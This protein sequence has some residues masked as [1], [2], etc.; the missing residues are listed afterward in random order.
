MFEIACNFIKKWEGFE[1]SPYLCPA[2]KLTIGY[3]TII[4]P[5]VKYNNVLG[6]ILL[7][8]SL[9]LQKQLRIVSKVNLSLKNKYPNLVSEI[10]A[11]ELMIIDLKK[12]WKFIAEYLPKG[13]TDNQCASILSLVYNIGVYAF[14]KST[15]L[16]LLQSNNFL[17]ASN[18][19]IKWNKASINGKKVE[20]KGLTN[21]RL[22]EKDLF[23][24]V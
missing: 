1:S 4:E 20:V 8:D 13:L 18:E 7:E 21:R 12:R 17:G 16:R 24:K 5:K 3:G 10:V 14:K 11:N 9:N 19:F 6:E 22:Q 23:L 15:L 2:N